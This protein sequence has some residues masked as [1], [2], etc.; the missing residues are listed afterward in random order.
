MPPKAL[1]NGGQV[2]ADEWPGT[3]IAGVG[4]PST[5]QALVLQSPRGQG[6]S[7]QGALQ[8][9]QH[10]VYEG[11]V[12]SGSQVLQA[13]GSNQYQAALSTSQL[14]GGS[15]GVKQDAFQSYFNEV[16][17]DV[18]PRSPQV[19][20]CY[21]QGDVQPM[22]ITAVKSEYPDLKRVKREYTLIEGERG[23]YTQGSLNPAV[24]L[25]SS[26]ESPHQE[27]SFQAPASSDQLSGLDRAPTSS[28]HSGLE[29]DIKPNYGVPHELVVKSESGNYQSAEIS[30]PCSTYTTGQASVSQ[31]SQEHGQQSQNHTHTNLQGAQQFMQQNNFQGHQSL[32]PLRN[33]GSMQ[34]GNFQGVLQSVGGVSQQPNSVGQSNANHLAQLQ[35]SPS[36]QSIMQMSSV[37]QLSPLQSQQVQA[38]A[39]AQGMLEAHAQSANQHTTLQHAVASQRGI[40]Q[41]RH[42]QGVSPQQQL[43]LYSGQQQQF[44]SGQAQALQMTNGL[45]LA[46][47]AQQM[48]SRMQ[49]AVQNQLLQRLKLGN[50]HLIQ[51]PVLGLGNFKGGNLDNKYRIRMP[52]RAASKC[53]HIIMLYI[54]E[55]RKRLPDNNIAFWHKLVHTFFEPGALKRWCLGSYNTSPV[56]R[57]A[58]GLFPMEFWF[59]NLCGVQP[60][61]GFESC[62]DVLPRLF[63]IKYDSGLV[64]ELLFLDLAEEY[65]MPSGKMVLEYSGAVHES[66]FAE[67]R[68]IRYGTLRVTFSSS[69]KIQA[70]EFCTKTHEEVVPSKNLQE[71]AQL[72]N[73]LVAEA[74]Q[75]DINKSVENLTKHCNA[76]MTSAKQLAVQLDAPMVN[77]LG[78]S[79]RYVRCLQISEVVNS[80][81]DLIS[82]ER[83]TRLGPLQSLAEFPSARKLQQ[84]GLLTNLPNQPSLTHVINYF[85]QGTPRQPLAS[86]QQGLVTR[87]SGGQVIL[88]N[89]QQGASQLRGH[90]LSQLQPG[91][92]AQAH[93]VPNMSE[94][95]QFSNHLQSQLRGQIDARNFGL[96]Q[97]GH[98]YSNQMQPPGP[99]HLSGSRQ[100]H[101]G[102]S[103]PTNELPGQL[104]TQM[105][106]SGLVQPQIHSSAHSLSGSPGGNAHS[107]SRSQ[108][109]LQLSHAQALSQLQGPSS[110][111]PVSASVL[112][113]DHASTDVN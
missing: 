77:D 7:E 73:N 34:A 8:S 107:F 15:E 64:D 113:G 21:P 63:K 44:Q 4:T 62:T 2:S 56:G 102:N 111:N 83:N 51:G 68:V 87:H 31:S 106:S 53:Y 35:R 108:I 74:E 11:R 69:Y 20:V 101:S 19:R 82:F 1:I 66:V 10:F 23:E 16:A 99:L 28:Q 65:V 57:H 91:A 22:D 47:A 70:W 41:A 100:A 81:K 6:S 86:F 37:S 50:R 71:Q 93:R 90:Q 27:G 84:Q 13:I 52:P 17:Q 79:K 30:S 38:Q 105:N 58:Q 104:Q 24:L 33:V 67:L 39:L 94:M 60:G 103:A 48:I 45:P 78:F 40:V 14:S 5:Q 36:Q 43:L 32:Q 80:M 97:A 54:H 75:E 59:C 95:V 92:V 72:L 61:R 29:G 9:K 110:T 25:R 98:A 26:Q 18:T 96:T 109:N 12:A 42:A 49:P 89:G 55:Q 46:G 112:N 88:P 85:I 3:T 76:F